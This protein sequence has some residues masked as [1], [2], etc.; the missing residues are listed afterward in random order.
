MAGDRQLGLEAFSH[1]V[2]TPAVVDAITKFRASP[3][4]LKEPA[5]VTLS[6]IVA[7]GEPGVTHTILVIYLS[8]I[9]I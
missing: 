2:D 4:G 6:Q 8:L 9:H 5:N 1:P 7:G 3:T